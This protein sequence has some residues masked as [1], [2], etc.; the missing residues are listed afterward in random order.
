MKHSDLEMKGQLH[1]SFFVMCLFC[2]GHRVKSAKS[3]QVVAP[4]RDKSF[5]LRD[6]AYVAKII[7]LFGVFLMAVYVV[8]IG[9]ITD[10]L[11]KA[12]EVRSGEFVTESKYIGYRHLM[13]FSSDAFVLFVAVCLGKRIGKTKITTGDKVFLFCASLFFVYYALSTGG[14]R[15][16]IYPILLCF[17]IY[18]SLGG[19]LKKT[20]VAAFALVFI[21]AGLGSFLAGNSQW[22]CVRCV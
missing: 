1:L 15:P 10:V 14:R 12:S 2:L 11:S 18:A 8:Q 5:S 21:I 7:F 3:T 17:L 22:E 20:A 13:Q 4:G 9:G 6:S 16:L 19:R